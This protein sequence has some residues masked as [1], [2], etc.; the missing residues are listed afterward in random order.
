ML[1][2]L[3]VRSKIV[4]WQEESRVLRLVCVRSEKH[5]GVAVLTTRGM[6]HRGSP[7]FRKEGALC[8]DQYRRGL[9]TWAAFVGTQEDAETAGDV[10][11]LESQITPV[12]KA[13]R[14]NGLDVVD[15]HHHMTED[16][17]VVILLHY[18]GTRSG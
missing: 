15:I 17:P 14:K 18:C 8:D 12:L 3:A 10:A 16:Y 6:D 7:R 13:L 4:E 2:R 9:N 1:V 5:F 11:M